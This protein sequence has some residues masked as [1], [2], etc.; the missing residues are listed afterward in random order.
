RAIQKIL[1]K[2]EAYDIKVI[3]MGTGNKSVRMIAWTFLAKEEQQVWRT[4]RWNKKE[5]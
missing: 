2:H 5:A 3:K 4:L 1:K